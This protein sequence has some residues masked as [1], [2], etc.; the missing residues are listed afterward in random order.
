MVVSHIS[1]TFSSTHTQTS[2]PNISF[3]LHQT[4]RKKMGEDEEEEEE[5]VLLWHKKAKLSRIRNFSPTFQRWG[6]G[7]GIEGGGEGKTST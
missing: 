7:G 2:H 5:A 6:E 3:F 4:G 1:D